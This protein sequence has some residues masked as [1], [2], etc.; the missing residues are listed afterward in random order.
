MDALRQNGRLFWLDRPLAELI[1]TADR[2]LGNS[3]EALK[4]RYEE[5][6]PLYRAAADERIDGT[7]SAGEAAAR[8]LEMIE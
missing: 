2:P 3:P 5:R 4:K 6:Y 8:I 1:P 7:R